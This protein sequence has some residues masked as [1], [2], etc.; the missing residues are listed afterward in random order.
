MS[1]GNLILLKPLP[2]RPQNIISPLKLNL[3]LFFWRQLRL[4]LLQLG[5][6]LIFL[7]NIGLKDFTFC[8]E[9]VNLEPY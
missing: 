7:L 8:L 1:L 9:V 4:R 5:Y 2:Q 6:L 3:G